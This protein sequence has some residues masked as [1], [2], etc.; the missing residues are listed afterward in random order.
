MFAT[1]PP[2]RGG[3]LKDR[4]VRG[5][6]FGEAGLS[7]RQAYRR[8]RPIGEAIEGEAIEGEVIKRQYPNPYVL[9]IQ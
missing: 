2:L 7:E 6:S 4:Q 1:R 3:Q 9:C 8:D 5:W